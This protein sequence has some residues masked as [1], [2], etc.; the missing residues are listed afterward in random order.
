LIGYLESGQSVEVV[1][2]EAGGSWWVI[3]VP[4]V[5]GGEGWVSASALNVENSGEV[6]VVTPAASL[7]TDEPT[8]GRT[9]TAIANVNVRE[10]PGMGYNKI[11]VLANGQQT[12]A[13]GVSG[14]GLWLVIRTEESPSGQGWVSVDYIVP[15]NT[16]GLP[17]FDLNTNTGALII[18]TPADDLPAA[19]ALTMVN[20]RSGPGLQYK[21][22]GRLEPGQRAEILGVS[23]DRSW[24]MIKIVFQ[25]QD[26][27]WIAVNFVQTENIDGI[28][29]IQ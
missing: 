15:Q 28:P 10:G 29:I 27:G 25:E 16:D 23:P 7:L 3:G 8:R 1:G 2:R 6:P 12:E 18:P 13:I 11:G 20:I 4:Y 26:R 9:V 24:W 22:L 17:V 19:T 21:V 5:E 14:D